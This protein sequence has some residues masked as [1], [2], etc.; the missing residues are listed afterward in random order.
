MLLC[1]MSEGTGL[2]D[3]RLVT[4]LCVGNSQV[5]MSKW[6][7]VGMACIKFY[8]ECGTPLSSLSLPFF[9]PNG[10]PI[11]LCPFYSDRLLYCMYLN[12]KIHQYKLRN[13][14]VGEKIKFTS[15]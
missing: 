2:E 4:V 1:A 9:S 3:R 14:Y 6:S 7:Q 11:C 10:H 12:F 5:A 13:M 15:K 8:T